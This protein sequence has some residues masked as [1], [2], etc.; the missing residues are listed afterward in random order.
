MN[1]S[2]H[3]LTFEKPWLVLPHED[4]PVTVITNGVVLPPTI[5]DEFAERVALMFNCAEAPIDKLTIRDN[6][7][8]SLTKLPFLCP[9]TIHPRAQ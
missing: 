4:V 9:L 1:S 7:R 6:Q 3:K 5:V 2:G 8:C